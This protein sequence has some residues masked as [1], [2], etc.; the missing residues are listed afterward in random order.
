MRLVSP[1]SRRVL[2]AGWR[3]LDAKEGKPVPVGAGDGVGNGGQG[4]VGPSVPL[5][6]LRQCC[7]RMGGVLPLPDHLRARL[8]AITARYRIRVAIANGVGDFAELAFCR[9][10]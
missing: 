3:P 4:L 8:N 5:K 2:V 10:R 1:R 6:S 9:G 7:D